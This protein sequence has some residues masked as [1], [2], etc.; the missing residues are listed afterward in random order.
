[1]EKTG[2]IP[3]EWNAGK[4][5]SYSVSDEQLAAYSKWSIEEK[6]AWIWETNKFLQAVQTEEERMLSQKL[7]HKVY[8]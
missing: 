3:K 8:R 1:M 7:K 6:L 5:F 2:I 4:G